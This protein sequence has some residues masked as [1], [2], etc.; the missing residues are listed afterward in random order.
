MPPKLLAEHGHGLV[1]QRHAD[2]FAA[3]RFVG[4]PMRCGGPYQRRTISVRARWHV[5]IPLQ[6]QNA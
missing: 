4:E 1:I 2:R 5:V 3:L 6:A